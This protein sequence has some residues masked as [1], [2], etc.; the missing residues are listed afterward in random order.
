MMGEQ[1]DAERLYRHIVFAHSLQH[2]GRNP[3]EPT[4]G[5][6]ERVMRALE[7][8]GLGDSTLVSPQ[9]WHSVD[10]V[11]PEIAVSDGPGGS[12]FGDKPVGTL[13]T[14]SFLAGGVSA[15]QWGEWG[16][17]GEWAEFGG[18]RRLFAVEFGDVE[19]WTIDSPGDVGELGRRYGVGRRISW[20]AVAED[21]DAVHLSVRGLLTA[22]HLGGVRGWDAESTAWLRPVGF[23]VGSA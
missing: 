15:W 4:P 21:F 10:G 9:A 22:G 1:V 11:V 20:A 2:S 8:T 13:W 14:S 18:G 23:R 19:V 17:W 12:V 7:E 3:P 5:A 6:V 16:E